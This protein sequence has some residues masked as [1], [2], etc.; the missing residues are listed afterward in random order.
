MIGKMI[1]IMQKYVYFVT[2]SHHLFKDAE[3]KQEDLKT[4]ICAEAN[5]NFFFISHMLV[6]K[7][8]RI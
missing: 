1:I 8:K 3:K 5:I 4:H 6:C 7:G 2:T